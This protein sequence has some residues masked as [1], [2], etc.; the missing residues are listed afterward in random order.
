[1]KK[2]AVFNDTHG[3]GYQIACWMLKDLGY[4]VYV[5]G[6]SFRAILPQYYCGNYAPW[7]GKTTLCSGVMEWKDM[8][9]DA[10][11]L[12]TFIETEERL[13]SNGFTGPYLMYWILP[14]WPDYIGKSFKPGKNV[15]VLAFN[16]GIGR[17]IRER[18]LCPVEFLWPPY[19]KIVDFKARESFDP[20]I[21]TVIKNLRGWSDEG[22]CARLRD[23]PLTNLDLYGG[24]PPDWSKLIGHHDLVV[25]ISRAIAMFHPKPTDTPGYA[26]MEAV[27]QAVPMILMPDF[28]RSTES[29]Y[30]FRNDETC[31]IVKNEE[32][33]IAAVE[34][35]KD[36][37]INKRIGVAC[38]DQLLDLADW[39]KNRERVANLI[40]KIQ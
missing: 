38:R 7:T 37:A 29:G 28:L 23:N 35:L 25:K 2:I 13:R 1:M 24:G 33:I 18:N 6:E 19:H 9:K 4:D 5:A 8:P 27:L 15:G 17:E 10:L 30:F 12:D 36:P 3:I 20:F 32:E 22:L 34:R 31:L 21:I 26:V 39:E 14:V 16:Y 40:Q 11:F